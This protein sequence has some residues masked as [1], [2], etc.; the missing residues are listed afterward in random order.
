MEVITNNN[1]IDIPNNENELEEEIQKLERQR[2]E[3]E[4]R[5]KDLAH[6]E[7]NVV[8]GGDFRGCA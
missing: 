6:K 5:L 3:V 8:G 2:V 7:R 1:N 4:K